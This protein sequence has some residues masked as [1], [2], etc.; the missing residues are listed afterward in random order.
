ML[1]VRRDPKAWFQGWGH[2]VNHEDSCKLARGPANVLQRRVFEHYRRCL[3][4][5]KPC[6]MVVLKYRRAGS[7]TASTATLYTHALN[8]PGAQ[9]GVI[10]NDY[11]AAHNMLEMMKVFGRN[12]RFAGWNGRAIRE[13]DYETV[14][15]EESGV[16]EIATKIEWPSGSKVQ[17]YT[18]IKPTSARSAGLLGYLATETAFWPVDG[19]TSGGETLTAMRNTLPKK[20]FHLCIEESTAHGA[21]G[22]HYETCQDARWPE[23][24]DWWKQWESDWPL[25]PADTES[26]R[27][28]QFVF[29]FAAWFEDSRHFDRLTPEDEQHIRDTIDKEEWYAGEQALIDRYA[30]D[31]PRGQRLGAEVD[32][33]VWEQLAWRRSIIKATKGLEN[34][35]QEYPSNPLEAFRSTGAPVFCQEGLAALDS[36]GRAVMTEHGLLDEQRE[37]GLVWR[38][39]GEQEC[40]YHLWEQPRDGCRYLMTVDGMTGTEIATSGRATRDRHSV[41]VW[42]DSYTDALGVYHDLRLV[43]RLKPPNQWDIDAMCA[44]AHR[45]ARYFGDCCIVVESNGPGAAIIKRLREL[46]AVLYQQQIPDK[47]KQTLETRLGWM[48]SEGSRRDAVASGQQAVREQVVDIPCA[49]LRAELKT[50]IFDKKGKPC[51]ST[52]HHDDDVLAFCIAV[53]CMAAATVYRAPQTMVAGFWRRKVRRKVA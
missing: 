9:L 23:Y 19:V 20:G 5:R 51:A 44:A 17:L 28:R 33:T 46:G 11:K 18:A 8:F 10:G 52:G 13:G 42:R 35:K 49:H 26:E 53:A 22:V 32:A 41:Q 38:R 6:R 14:P 39:T 12:D 4:E 1:A 25:T 45:L 50:F 47:V 24:A 15:W 2:W 29:I 36:A 30:V 3:A 37:H 48:N 16:K 27:D 21:M 34:F 40:V 7:S 31:G 43:A